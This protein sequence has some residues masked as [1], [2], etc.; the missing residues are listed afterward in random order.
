MKRSLSLIL[1]L[2][3]MLSV[4]VTLPVMGGAVA[5]DG[6]KDSGIKYTESTEIIKNPFL[7]YPGV[8]YLTIEDDMVPRDDGGRFYWYYVNLQKFSG[9]NDQANTLRLCECRQAS[10]VSLD[11]MRR[12]R[13][14]ILSETLCFFGNINPDKAKALSGF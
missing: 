5:S 11:G 6:L 12:E 8:G 4:W 1:S 9:G 13:T 14:R 7:G 10:I 3:M 2:L